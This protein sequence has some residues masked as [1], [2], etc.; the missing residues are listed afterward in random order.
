[1]KNAVATATYQDTWA[2]EVVAYLMPQKTTR[3]GVRMTVYRW[4]RD[5]GQTCDG[6]VCGRGVDRMMAH[7]EWH[8]LFSNVQATA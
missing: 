7:A 4:M 3:R 1:M 6:M 8:A 5:N 2:G